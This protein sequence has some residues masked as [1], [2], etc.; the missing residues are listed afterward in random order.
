MTFQHILGIAGV[1]ALLIGVGLYSGRKVSGTKDFTTGGG[2]AGS[3]LVC[4]SIMGALVG[5][6]ATI[7]TA[8]LAFNYGLSAWW[9]TLGSGIGSLL[10]ALFY[11]KPLRESGCVT[12]LSIIA[13]EYGGRA[14]EL[15]SALCSIGIFI[16]V[17]AQ[18]VACGGLI[19]VLFPSV[20]ILPAMVISVLLM[21][22]YVIFG[23]AWGAGMGGFV[24]LLLLCLACFSG[25][26]FIYIWSGGFTALFD[27][28][29]N[30]FLHTNI[31]KAQTL[32]GLS[33]IA[34]HEDFSARF[35]S[36]VA[37]GPVKDIGSGISLLLGVLSTQTYAQ[38]ILSGR[39]H[40]AARNGALINALIIPPLGIAG[41]MIGLYM[42]A[43]Y[44][45]ASE[46]AAL[47]AA[48]LP[49][50]DMPILESTI[51]AFPAFALN[52]LPPVFAGVI[53]GTLFI[54]VIG[55]G[56]GLTLG[57]ATIITNDILL[58][59]FPIKSADTKDEK[60]T[61]AAKSLLMIRG[62]IM[63]VLIT[64]GVIGAFVPGAIIN[65][66]GFLSMGL[67]GAVVFVPLSLA[68]FMPGKISPRSMLL[69]IILSPL[70]VLAANFCHLPGDPLFYGMGMSC[71]WAV[72]GKVNK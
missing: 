43:H 21:A 11:T 66:F 37:R 47:T 51:Q 34:G 19:S 9:F 55:G 15:G 1:L 6:Q 65:D 22:V 31:G 57:V 68:L 10:L 72:I 2:K 24:K 25:L 63:A 28:I 7:G 53:I 38:A 14:G 49:L 69:S 58:K 17:L 41:V 26:I 70:A 32:I 45:L 44:M 35:L 52:H 27:L 62:T 30:N 12:E 23:G 13:K 60:G 8:Q 20:G 48:G 29:E 36:L 56:A 16:S 39:S 5:S 59:F 3:L 64:A 4:G 61:N 67:R 54:S 18:F 33:T 40:E 50:P 71:L 46:A 42:R